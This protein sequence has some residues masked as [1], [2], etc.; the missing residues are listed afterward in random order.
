MLEKLGMPIYIT[1]MLV[2]EIIIAIA[3]ILRR[4]NVENIA[5]RIGIYAIIGTIAFAISYKIIDKIGLKS[6]E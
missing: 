4:M 2:G 5:L 6:G 1:V 3:G